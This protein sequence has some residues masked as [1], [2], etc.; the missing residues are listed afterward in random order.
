MSFGVVLDNL[1]GKRL[2]AFEMIIERSLEDT[3]F[4]SNVLNRTGLVTMESEAV[5]GSLK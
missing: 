4:P 5:H 3:R 2:L 1:N